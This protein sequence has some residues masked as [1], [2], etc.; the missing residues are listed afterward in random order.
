MGDCNG[1]GHVTVDELVRGADIA[2]GNAMLIS[3]PQFD[4]NANGRVTVDCLVKAIDAA[5]KGCGG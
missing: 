2:L 4:C 3:C 5:V 1:N